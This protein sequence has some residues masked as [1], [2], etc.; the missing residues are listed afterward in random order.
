MATLPVD[1]VQSRNH[2][3]HVRHTF[4]KPPTRRTSEFIRNQFLLMVYSSSTWTRHTYTPSRVSL[5]VTIEKKKKI[6][7]AADGHVANSQR[8]KWAVF[9]GRVVTSNCSVTPSISFFV[10]NVSFFFFWQDNGIH[11][12]RN[13]EKWEIVKIFDFEKE[14]RNKLWVSRNA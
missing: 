3:L 7:R 1:C 6:R 14:M 4:G 11:F 2:Q 12:L 9:K 10:L 8:C 13:R 5:S